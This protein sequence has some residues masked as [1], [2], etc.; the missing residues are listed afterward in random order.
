MH[1]RLRLLL[2]Q[3]RDGLK[4]ALDVL[5]HLAHEARAEA[6]LCEEVALPLPRGLVEPRQEIYARRVHGVEFGKRLD[7]AR[8]IHKRHPALRPGVL[9]HNGLDLRQVRKHLRHGDALRLEEARVAGVKR[10]LAAAGVVVD[11]YHRAVAAEERAVASPRAEEL[12]ASFQPRGLDRGLDLRNGRV[13]VVVSVAVEVHVARHRPRIGPH[14]VLRRDGA[15]E[16]PFDHRAL[17]RLHDSREAGR[18]DVL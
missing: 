7:D 11:N 18:L 17:I 5:R 8:R 16:L 14:E 1:K 9:E 15:H 10:V 12:D 3:L 6:M 13:C 2:Q 4:L